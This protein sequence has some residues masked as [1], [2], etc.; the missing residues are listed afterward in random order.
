MNTVF[1]SKDPEGTGALL[2]FGV[3]ITHLDELSFYTGRC[4]VGRFCACGHASGHQSIATVSS[5]AVDESQTSINRRIGR[6]AS[7]SGEGER[8][9]PLL[10][11]RCD[12]VNYG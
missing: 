2:P 5:C 9:T 12:A 10:P 11:N 1:S 4:T 7:S 8:K 6:V 3:I